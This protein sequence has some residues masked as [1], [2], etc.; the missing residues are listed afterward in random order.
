MKAVNKVFR[1]LGVQLVQW[2][3]TVRARRVMLLQSQNVSQ[4]ID[5]G[6]NEGQYARDLRDSG[7]RGHIISCEPIQALYEAATSAAV[8]DPLWDVHRVAIG[9]AV[10][11]AEIGVAGLDL[12]SSLLQPTSAMVAADARATAVRTEVVPTTTLDEFVREHCSDESLA[13]KI[14]AQGAE[15][16]I[17][18]GGVET[19]RRARILE[20]ELSPVPLYEGEVGLCE[21]VARLEAA[22]Y[23][24]ALVENVSLAPGGRTLQVNGIFVRN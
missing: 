3:L 12:Y 8:S 11:E 9:A 15:S 24:L 1:R 21:T 18:D 4:L 20:L 16:M 13:V 6:A 17:L 2:E 5:I 19:L 22:A 7:Y 23:V 10:G 14:D